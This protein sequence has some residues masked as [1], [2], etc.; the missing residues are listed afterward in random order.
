MP[1]GTYNFTIEQGA[2]FGFSLTY[3]DGSGV[4]IDLSGFSCARMQWNANNN[5]VYQF[6]TS[7]TNSGLYLFEFGSPPS[8][9]II[10]FKIPASVTAGYNF[11]S[12]NYDMEL[13][14]YAVFYSGG[15]PQ[16]T[17]LLQGTVTVQ[18]EITKFSCSGV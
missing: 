4:P 14:S 13:E 7:N 3:A 10:N 9:G 8:S 12:A 1:A 15:G 11:T 17:R 5:S 18:P 6:T 16:I 2:S